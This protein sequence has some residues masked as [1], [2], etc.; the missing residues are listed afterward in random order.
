MDIEQ[1]DSSFTGK[2]SAGGIRIA[3]ADPT[4]KVM[5]K[6]DGYLIS[7]GIKVFQDSSLFLTTKFFLLKSGR[8]RLENN[9]LAS[10]I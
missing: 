1:F 2:E 3:F 8:N 4:D 5:M 10:L 9:H 6:Q 7:P